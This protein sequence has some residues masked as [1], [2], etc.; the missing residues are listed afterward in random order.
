MFGRNKKDKQTAPELAAVLTELMQNEIAVTA[1]KARR[2]GTMPVYRSKFGGKPAVPAGFEWPRFEAANYEDEVA[3]RPL[4]FLGQIHLEEVKKYDKG[5]VLPEKGLLLFFYEQESM[6]WGFDPK[7]AGCAR[8]YYFEDVDTLAEAEFPADLQ[9]EYKGKEYSLSFKA[10]DSYP[11]FEEFECYSDLACDWEDYDDVVAQ[12]G[13]EPECERHK[14]LGYADLIQGEMLT[15][16]ERTARGICCGN[17]ASYLSL[18]DE[19]KAE[20]HAAA[21]EWVL[22]FQM[23][24]IMDNGYELMFGDVGNLYFYIRKAD[25]QERR[26]D[27]VW[28]VLQC[29]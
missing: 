8:V 23:A 6:R 14:L 28:M 9:E 19:V 21:G 2:G 29:G 26:F 22:L 27:R 25:L 24:S 17:P 15:E 20:I 12:Q 1:K 16:C 5:Q 13:Y 18:S 4:S 7:D 11:C 3:N 10:Q